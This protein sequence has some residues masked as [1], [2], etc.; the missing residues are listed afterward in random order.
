MVGNF[1]LQQL[2]HGLGILGFLARRPDRP[3]SAGRM[4]RPADEGLAIFKDQW[5]S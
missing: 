4:R 5:D 2:P 3:S 1:L